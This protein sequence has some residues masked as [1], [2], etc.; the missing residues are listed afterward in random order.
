MNLRTAT[1]VAM[2]GTT[3]ALVVRLGMF[4]QQV[5]STAAASTLPTN[6]P[7][8]LLQMA[9]YTIADVLGYASLLVFFFAVRRSLGPGM[10]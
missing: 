2:I 7:S 6:F 8:L 4:A 1:T 10:S 9:G 3:L 5:A